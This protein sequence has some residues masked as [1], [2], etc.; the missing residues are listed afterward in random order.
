VRRL[1][2]HA[3]GDAASAFDDIAAH[4]RGAQ[5]A[6]FLPFALADHDAYTSTIAERLAG[7]GV[8]ITGLHA[9]ADPAE[10]LAGAD[11]IVVGGGNSFRLVTALH[12]LALIEP[13]RELVAAGVP[14]FGASAGTNV[15]CPTV[16]TTNDMPIVQPPSLAAFDLV[17]FQVNPHYI[18]APAPEL[19]VGETRAERL[20]EFLEE[21]DVPVVG[22]REQSWLIVRDDEMRLHG[23]AGAVLF[24]RDADPEELVPG[25]DLSHLLSVEP[26]FDIR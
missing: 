19:R 12:Q 2:L 23:T 20:R 11:A 17:P 3:G 18:D 15:A 1:L 4:L 21:N 6:V 24:R 26:R 5:R 22:L 14:Y 25:E 10:M 8:R 7:L 13:V 9:A 16:R